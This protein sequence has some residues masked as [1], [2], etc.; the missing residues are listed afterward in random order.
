MTDQK[1]ETTGGDAA[2]GEGPGESDKSVFDKTPQPLTEPSTEH[3]GRHGN[4]G[5]ENDLDRAEEAGREGGR[6]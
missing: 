5:D 4:A 1:R 2:T 3:A 6:R